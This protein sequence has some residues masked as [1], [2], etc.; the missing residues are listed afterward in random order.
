MARAV[1]TLAKGEVSK[2][3]QTSQRNGLL[4][5]CE[6]RESGDAAKA[7]LLSSQVRDEVARLQAAQL[8]ELWRKWNL[9]RLGYETTD[10]SSVEEAEDSEEQ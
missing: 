4:V 6:N 1:R 10:A 2:F 3:V 9:E 7:T 5:V 8:P